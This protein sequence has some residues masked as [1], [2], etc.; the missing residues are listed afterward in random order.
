MDCV[1]Y[2]YLVGLERGSGR[3]DSSETSPIR[4]QTPGNYPKRNKLHLEHGESLKTRTNFN[5]SVFKYILCTK[6]FINKAVKILDFVFEYS[7]TFHIRPLPRYTGIPC[8]N[9]LLFLAQLPVYK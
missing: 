4:T 2:L 1:G 8:G 3:A 9:P 6:L 5:F 7:I